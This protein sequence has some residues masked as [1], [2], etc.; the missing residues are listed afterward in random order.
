MA[1]Y[2]YKL[3]SADESSAKL[4]NCDIC[5]K[6]AAEVYH[7]TEEKFYRIDRIKHEGWTQHGCK[8]LFGHE[9][10]LLIARRTTC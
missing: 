4:G 5:G 9:E 8:T 7:Q 3:S 10:C 2:R 6:H 1:I